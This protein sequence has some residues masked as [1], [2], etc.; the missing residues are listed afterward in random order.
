[1]AGPHAKGWGLLGA[2]VVLF[3]F[4]GLGALLSRAYWNGTRVAFPPSAWAAEEPGAIVVVLQDGTEIK[5]CQILSESADQI[6]IKTTFSSKVTLKRSQIKEI[7]RVA[8]PLRLEWED[9]Y[10]IAS[11]KRDV[12]GLARVAAWASENKMAEETRR[13][14]ERVVEIQPEHAAARTALGHGRLDGEWVGA[15]RVAALV[16]E[17]WVL[18]GLD[19]VAPKGRTGVPGGEAKRELTP[20]EKKRKEKADAKAR[21]VAERYRK[22]K[23]LEYAGVPWDDR[24][25]LNTPHYF[26]ECNSTRDV[27]NAYHMIMEKLFEVLSKRITAPDERD[28]KSTVKIYRNHAEFMQMENLPEVVGAYYNPA[29]QNIVAYHGTF[30]ATGSTFSTLAHEATHQFQGRKLGMLGMN[31]LPY[32][33]VEGMAVYYGDG[34]R[35]DPDK[36]TIVTGLVPRDRLLHLQRKLEEG[37]QERL[38]ALA[39]YPRIDGSQY[40]DAWALMYFMFDGPKK[41]KG[42]EFIIA[43]WKLAKERKT[44][45][46]DFVQLADQHFGG[47]AALESELYAFVKGLAPEPTGKVTADSFES[48]EFKFSMKLPSP[49]WKFVDNPRELGQLAALVPVEEKPK[50]VAPQVEI[51]LWN[52]LDIDEPDETF[53]A[54]LNDAVWAKRYKLIEQKPIEHV[55]HNVVAVTYLDQEPASPAPI[56]G[57]GAPPPTPG[58]SEPKPVDVPPRRKYLSYFFFLPDKAYELR[59]SSVQDEFPQYEPDFTRAMENLSVKLENRW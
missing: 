47:V 16:K 5:D 34:S 41:E 12:E 13:T 15:E 32:W 20:E 30:G 25:K 1:M 11:E 36:K 57:G 50:P 49:L 45:V 17:G 8:N 14:W 10:R 3:A 28:Q 38:K 22:Q 53:L 33:L 7:R 56:A 37:T 55:E 29:N 4:A 26:I 51:R 19:L 59:G 6:V 42:R 35:I 58:G 9:R 39:G 24:W 23:E 52:K 54:R 18:E 40:S 27:A 48:W 46:S 31:N 21:K 2:S 44:T 43:L